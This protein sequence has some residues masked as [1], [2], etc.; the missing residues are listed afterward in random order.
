MKKYMA[1]QNMG[2]F[3]VEDNSLRG[4]GEAEHYPIGRT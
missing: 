2:K 3:G 4:E 1:A